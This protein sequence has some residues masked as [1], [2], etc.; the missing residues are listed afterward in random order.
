MTEAE[1]LTKWCPFARAICAS[2]APASYNRMDLGE[3]SHEWLND[4]ETCCVG[5]ACMAWRGSASSGFCGLAGP[6]Q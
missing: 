3:G 5:T 1:A 6:V 4:K 2:D